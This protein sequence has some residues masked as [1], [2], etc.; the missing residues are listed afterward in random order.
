[1]DEQNPVVLL[2]NGVWHIVEHSRRS[3]TARCGQPLHERQA[4]SR[5]K[6]IGKEHVCTKCFKI[7][8][9]QSNTEGSVYG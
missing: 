4:H 7:F 2:S 1:M 3:D 9:S 6:T 5:L 8:A